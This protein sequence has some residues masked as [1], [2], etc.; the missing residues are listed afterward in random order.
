MNIRAVSE[1]AAAH[2]APGRPSVRIVLARALPARAT[3]PAHGEIQLNAPGITD[4]RR[5]N[6]V[7]LDPTEHHDTVLLIIFHNRPG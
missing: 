6:D 7:V 5:E 1:A 3:G 4:F 2:G